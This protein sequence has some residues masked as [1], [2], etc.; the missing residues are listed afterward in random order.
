MIELSARVTRLSSGRWRLVGGKPLDQNICPP[1]LARFHSHSRLQLTQ[2]SRPH[3]LAC[4][5]AR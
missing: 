2:A 1:P 5:L 4:L 3:L